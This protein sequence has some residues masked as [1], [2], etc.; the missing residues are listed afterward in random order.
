MFAFTSKHH[1]VSVQPDRAA[2][3]A[4]NLGRDRQQNCFNFNN[5]KLWRFLK[6]QNKWWPPDR[7]VLSR[8]F[9]NFAFSH[10]TWRTCWHSHTQ[11]VRFKLNWWSAW[12][13]TQRIQFRT[14]LCWGP[15]TLFEWS[16]EDKGNHI[17]GPRK[18]GPDII[19]SERLLANARRCCSR[20]TLLIFRGFGRGQWQGLC[21]P[22]SLIAWHGRDVTESTKQMDGGIEKGWRDVGEEENKRIVLMVEKGVLWTRQIAYVGEW[23]GGREGGTKGQRKVK[24]GIFFI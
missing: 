21:L 23:G 4:V 1:C 7:K 2:S 10:L 13:V 24:P 5:G 20:K 8:A 19:K 17:K 3:M 6:A 12:W 18:R 9:T 16:L 11:L 14:L 15:K 22:F